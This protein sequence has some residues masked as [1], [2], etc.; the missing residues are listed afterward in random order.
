MK[1]FTLSLLLLVSGGCQDT[2]M[3]MGKINVNIKDS[4]SA[5]PKIYGV[6][7]EHNQLIVT[8]KNLKG[9]SV[10]KIQ[11]GTNHNFQIESKTEE[12]L[13]LNAKNALTLLVGGTFN[14]IVSNA[15][16]SATFP[17][18]VEL[19]SMG[20]A[21]G[22]YLRFNGTNW[23]PASITNTQIFA[24]S[25]DASTD[26]P[27]IVALGGTAGSYYIVT[28]A[29]IQDLGAGPETYGVGDWVIFNGSSWI[30]LEAQ[31][32]GGVTGF[33]GRTGAVV[34]LSGDYSWSMLTKAAG[35]LNG[36]KLSEIADVDVTGIQDGDVIQ[37]NAADSK[38]EAVP[39]PSPTI[40][41]GSITTTQIADSAI[42]SD[43][44]IDGSIVNADISATAA[45]A[46]SKIAGLTTALNDKE[47]TIP[48]G[49][50]N[51]YVRGDKTLGSFS[52]SFLNTVLTGYGMGTAIPITPLDTI[53]QALG[54]LEAKDATIITS[55]ASYVP[56]DG[57]S[58]MTGNLQLGGK[59]ITNL[60]DPSGNSDAANKKY[61]DDKVAAIGAGSTQWTTS[62]SDIYYDTG[63]VGIGTA[64]PASKLH[65][66]SGASLSPSTNANSP[67]VIEGTTSNGNVNIQLI[68]G[69]TRS[70]SILFADPDSSSGAGYSGA[71]MYD[72]G[73]DK[74]SFRT[75][76]VAVDRLLIDSS[77]NVGIGTTTPDASAALDVTSTSSGFLLPRMTTAQRNAIPS[78]ANGLMVFDTD[79]KSLFVYQAT[80]W[81]Q[82]G[83][84]LMSLEQLRF[85]PQRHSQAEL[86]LMSSIRMKNMTFLIRTM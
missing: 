49:T 80:V 22:Q 17:I 71:V 14:L 33:N 12:K 51:D 35:K 45:I 3:I 34:P 7:I 77:G 18:T 48:T 31:A 43:K 16:A 61:V 69:N 50:V 76:V 25:Y 58:V 82:V 73:T 52:S 54:K 53:N 85:L 15:S 60:G 74:M 20:A 8:G 24:G 72:H 75:G 27:D 65:L 32:T 6:R 83:D 47:P 81:R 57:S 29:G 63:R 9:V 21:A 66:V 26:S 30:K 5:P 42:D 13:V 79:I 4:Y 55:Q 78:P 67:L 11:G 44:I 36:S 46:Q 28:V 41:N 68:S 86:R 19:P 39:A 56:L 23:V 64:S 40:T 1:V 84:R 2:S 62:G 70:T 59:L 37:W 38:W 10:A